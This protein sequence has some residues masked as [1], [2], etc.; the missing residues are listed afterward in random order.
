MLT[1]GGEADQRGELTV[2]E[3]PQPGGRG[4]ERRR[5]LTRNGTA[6]TCAAF[7]PDPDKPFVVVGT[8]DGSVS[9]WAAPGRA[10]RGQ[11]MVGTV[12]SALPADARSLTLRVE[13]P[14]PLEGGLVDRSQATIIL[15]PG[16][17]PA[18]PPPAAPGVRPAGGVVDGGQVIPAG[19]IAPRPAAAAP[20]RPLPPTAGPGGVSLPALGSPPAGK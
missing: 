19:G 18:A 5:L 1:A 20:A 17:E 11:Q 13:M 12:V 6:V 15:T 9:Y 3:V 7:S 14:N 2:W 8:A 4:A 16:A 10:E